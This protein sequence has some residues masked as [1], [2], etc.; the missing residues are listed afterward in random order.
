MTETVYK[1]VLTYTISETP[2]GY[3][4]IW[5]P[6]NTGATF[7]IDNIKMVN[8]DEQA[9]LVNV[10][11]ESAKMNVPE[12]YE[13]TAQGLKYN[14]DVTTEAETEMWYLPLVIVAGSCIIILGAT[15]ATL[16]IKKKKD[17]KGEM[18]DEKTNS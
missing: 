1:E 15:V 2:T 4:H 8:K 10:E 13:Y 7:A 11:F 14:P 17:R 6:S 18:A 12:D 9:N 3:V 5:A 16:E